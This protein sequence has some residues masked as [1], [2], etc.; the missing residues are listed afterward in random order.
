MWETARIETPEAAL[1]ASGYMAVMKEFGTKQAD[2]Y[3]EMDAEVPNGGLS[4]KVRI[5]RPCT[6]LTR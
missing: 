3:R 2:F 5:V 4:K 1:E 6:R